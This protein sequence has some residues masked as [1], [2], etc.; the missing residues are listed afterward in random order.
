M[1]GVVCICICIHVY[2]YICIYVCMYVYVCTVYVCI[3]SC[4]SRCRCVFCF[5]VL[6]YVSVYMHIYTHTH[7][8]MLIYLLLVCRCCYYV[9][10]YIYMPVDCYVSSFSLNT[11]ALAADEDRAYSKRILLNT[12]RIQDSR[13][14]VQGKVLPGTLNLESWIRG[15]FNRI[16]FEYGMLWFDIAFCILSLSLFCGLVV[17]MCSIDTIDIARS[18]RKHNTGRGNISTVP[19]CLCV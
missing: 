4:T 9:Y 15:V 18:L 16:R 17:I 7:T 1:Y 2:V 19:C 3:C 12:P 8:H 5:R 10:I 6:I 11:K 13:F 14:K